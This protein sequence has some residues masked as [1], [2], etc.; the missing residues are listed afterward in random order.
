MTD[1]HRRSDRRTPT[2]GWRQTAN[3]P[4]DDHIQ[5]DFRR[6]RWRKQRPMQQE[7][8]ENFGAQSRRQHRP[9]KEEGWFYSHQGVVPNM[10]TRWRQSTTDW[11][12]EENGVRFQHS[13]QLNQ[14][15]GILYK[16]IKAKHHLNQISKPTLPNFLMNFTFMLSKK[17]TPALT[18][19]FI[20]HEIG[21]NAKNWQRST[22]LSLK[23]HYQR[24]INELLNDLF[25]LPEIDWQLPFQTATKWIKMNLGKRLRQNTITQVE[26]LLTA[27]AEEI[28]P[29]M[30]H[31]TEIQTPPRPQQLANHPLSTKSPSWSTDWTEGKL[32]KIKKSINELTSLLENF[33]ETNLLGRKQRSE[34]HQ[35]QMTTQTETSGLRTGEMTTQT[36]EKE[37][38]THHRTTQTETTRWRTRGVGVQVQPRP[39]SESTKEIQT[40]LA[41]D[42]NYINKLREELRLERAQMGSIKPELGEYNPQNIK[43]LTCYSITH[44]DESRGR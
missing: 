26:E 10:T 35:R 31:S 37:P 42:F 20:Q 27:K 36:E 33:K 2:G 3:L 32:T 38:G 21:E 14:Q 13:T 22:L 18:S 6:S 41:L 40:Y 39:R 7:Q 30:L 4:E 29:H 25:N 1:P 11:T 12:P 23:T 8:R 5:G 28:E 44:R 24:T 16:I 15:V 34:L 17:V 43:P 19:T 9:R